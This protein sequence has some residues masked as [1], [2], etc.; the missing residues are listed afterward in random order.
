[1]ENVDN[2]LNPNKILNQL[3]LR[4]DM[5]AGDFGCG[6]GGWA[7]PLAKKL[8]DGKVY[9]LDIQEEML[10][11]L[12]SHSQLE[13]IY[14]IETRLCDLEREGGSGLPENSLD[15]VLLT[16]LL[17]QLEDKK[18]VLKEIKKV[19]KRKGVL[20]IVDWQPGASFGPREGRISAEEVKKLASEVGLKLKKEFNASVHH[21][22]LIFIKE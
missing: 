10:S 4:K 14:N 15:L 21:Y 12:K 16:N 3:K 18:T 8:E 6:T 22:G 5:I 11:A 2:F 1:M 17:F 20:L 19:L 7:I 9:A 13:K